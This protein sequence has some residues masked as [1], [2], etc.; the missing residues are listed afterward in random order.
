MAS[1]PFVDYQIN[2]G[3]VMPI[4]YG[5]SPAPTPLGYNPHC[6][7][8]NLSAYTAIHWL[9]LGNILNVTLGAASCSIIHF[10]NELQGRFNDGFL[11]LHT[12]GHGVMG[13]VSGDSFSSPVDPVFWLHHA[14]V[15]RVYWLGQ[16][17]HSFQAHTV[18]GIIKIFNNPPSRNTSVDDIIDLGVNTAP[19]AIG[20][21]L[22]TLGGDPMCYIYK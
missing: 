6:L 16:A 17:L 21:V 10:Q 3:P 4:Q 22:N 19:I 14:M 20:N 5:M 1:G 7:S 12:A 11:G 2:L 9:T 8:C 18:A 13:G 15:D